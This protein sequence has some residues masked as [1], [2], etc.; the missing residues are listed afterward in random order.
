MPNPTKEQIVHVSTT[1]AKTFDDAKRIAAQRGGHLP[2]MEEYID[3]ITPTREEVLEFS[4]NYL[5][6]ENSYLQQEN[7]ALRSLVR[8]M[9]EA[10]KGNSL[11]PLEV[12]A[13]CAEANKAIGAGERLQSGERSNT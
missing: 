13:L 4:C 2:T 7:T 6:Q 12:D 3:A 5:K 8:R 11:W 1:E 10:L 9:R